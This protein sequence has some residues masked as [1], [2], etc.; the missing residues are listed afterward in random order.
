[1]E[2]R[3]KIRADFESLEL[4]KKLMY[5]WLNFKTFKSYL[6]KFATDF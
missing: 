5:V 4:E 6:I 1:M 3:E 2:D